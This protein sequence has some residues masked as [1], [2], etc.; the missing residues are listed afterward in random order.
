M[1]SLIGGITFGIC[2]NIQLKAVKVLDQNGAGSSFTISAGINYIIDNID[3]I[4]N[5]DPAIK[6]LVANLSLGGPASTAIDSAVQQL[7]DNNIAVSVAAGNEDDD[8]CLYSPSRLSSVLSVGASDINDIRPVFSNFGSCVDLSAPG[9]DVEGAWLG[10]NTD[11]RILSGTSMAS[12]LVCGV[13]ALVWQMD[14]S[15]TNIQVQNI[16]KAWA[17]PNIVEGASTD[18][19]GKNLLYSLI[20][21]LVSPPVVSPVPT[22]VPANSN[23]TKFILT[24]LLLLLF[25]IVI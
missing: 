16:V 6:K 7:I 3:A 21:P 23:I 12:P 24:N 18:G 9:V 17:T 5:G 13:L 1:S 22:P 20:N 10:S 19:G 14:K 2:K 11:T 25:I 15:L 4:R 8:A